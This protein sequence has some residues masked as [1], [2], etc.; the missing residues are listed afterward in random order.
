MTPINL[1]TAIFSEPSVNIIL[2]NIPSSMASTSMVA[3]SVST[4]AITSPGETFSPSFF[5]HVAIFPS[6]IVGDKAGIKIGI[7]IFVI[8]YILFTHLFTL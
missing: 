1:F 4:S 7:G 3:L 8:P 6:V 5:N 2:D